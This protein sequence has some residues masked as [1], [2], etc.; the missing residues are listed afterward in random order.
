MGLHNKTR[1]YVGYDW[2]DN[3]LG[4]E[5]SPAS[6]KRFGAW[7][8]AVN[9]SN[10]EDFAWTLLNFLRLRASVYQGPIMGAWGSDYRFMNA[11]IN[12]MNM[13]KI[14][15]EINDN[16]AKY[17][18]ASIR[19]ATLAECKCSRSLCVFLR[20]LKDAAAQTRTISTAS[21]YASRYIDGQRTLS[22]AGR[23]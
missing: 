11:S 3:H 1:P 21:K 23:T 2:S 18:N 16:P 12:Y 15:S 13:K 6:H 8:G 19:F 4:H 17:N 22:T 9:A 5:D 20:S 10:V 7:S 14:H